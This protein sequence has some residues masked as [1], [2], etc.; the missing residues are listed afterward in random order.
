MSKS[1]D[2]ESHSGNTKGKYI[3]ELFITGATANSTRAIA[4]IKSICENHLKGNY[5][6]KI[7]DVYEERELAIKNQVVALP[8]L[9]KRFPLPQR[10][11]IGDLSKTEK[12]LEG[13]EI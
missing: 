7:I 9:I 6:L 2:S 3:L 5:E 11:L 8:M 10:K 1:R 12:V 4:N 13:L